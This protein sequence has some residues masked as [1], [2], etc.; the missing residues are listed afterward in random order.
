MRG[1]AALEK[2]LDNGEVGGVL[3]IACLKDFVAVG[4]AS[5]PKTGL[6]SNRMPARMR[7]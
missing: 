4:T 5:W 6:L 2:G 7:R 1:R 3:V